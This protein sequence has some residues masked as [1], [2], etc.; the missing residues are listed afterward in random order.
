MVLSKAEQARL[1]NLQQELVRYF[2]TMMGYPSAT[3]LSF[4][5][6]QPF[7][8]LP[9]NNIGDPFV[10]SGTYKLGT[11]EYEREVVEFWARLTNAPKDNWWGYITNGGTEGNL[12]GLYLA[13]ELYPQGIV[14][15]SQD[16]HYSVAKSLHLL[17]MRNIMIR[18]Q[19]N[20]EIDYE[21]LRETLKIKR[22]TP[23]IILAN[24]GTTMTEA[25]DNIGT[26]K[27][28]MEELAI[29]QYY[30]HSDAAM[31]GAMAPFMEP[32]PSFDFADGAHSIAISGHKFIGS[33]IPCGIVL[34]RKDYVNRVARSIAYIGS[35][36][37][38][39]SGSRNGLT[40][41]LLWYAMKAFGEEGMRQRVKNSVQ[42]AEYTEQ[43]LQKTGVAAWRNPGALTVVMPRVKPE[44]QN[45]WQ[46]ASDQEISHIMLMPSKHITRDVIDEL[47]QD[48]ARTNT[49]E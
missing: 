38:T 41:L 26:I 11:K 3:D 40:P 1:D 6:L 42:L 23:P 10:K 2:G 12:Y 21:D 14:Y 19:P 8:E 25:K 43:A 28:I 37:T 30:I 31:S 15:F 18:R 33:T 47:V 17:N 39:I 4:K 16:S 48:I 44:V 45:K 27:T 5:A 34:T 29:P 32:K 13:R 20:G 36:D 35:L 7:M 49:A 9:L 46:L 22:D 24:I